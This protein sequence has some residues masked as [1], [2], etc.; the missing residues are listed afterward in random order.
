[1]N[2]M[3]P[4]II[5]SAK[6]KES[7]VSGLIYQINESLGVIQTSKVKELVKNLSIKDKEILINSG[8]KIETCLYVPKLFENNQAQYFW[9]LRQIFFEVKHKELYP[10]IESQLI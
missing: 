7:K 2:I 1:M 9:H 6:F 4:L 5:L 8:V 3:H 10:D